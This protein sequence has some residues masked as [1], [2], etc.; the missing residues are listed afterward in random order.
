MYKL[1]VICYG[2][3]SE[4]QSFIHSF[5]GYLLS[6]YNVLCSWYEDTAMNKSNKILLSWNLHSSWKTEKQRNVQVLTVLS[7]M[8]KNN[9]CEE[10]V[11][12]A[13]RLQLY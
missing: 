7:I 11:M 3:I 4:M 5:H 1:E 10:V 6:T 12:E 9:G 8:M 2:H 13:I